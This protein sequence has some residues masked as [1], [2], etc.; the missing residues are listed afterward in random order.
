VLLIGH[1]ATRWAL[2]H[3]LAGRPLTELASAEFD[4]QPGWTY[5][6]DG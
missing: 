3:Y 6:L 2:D 1:V 5:R 4:W